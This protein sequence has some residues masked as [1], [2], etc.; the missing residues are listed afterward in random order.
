MTTR[1]I[2]FFFFNLKK[3]NSIFKILMT[4]K[5]RIEY[6]ALKPTACEIEKTPI[7]KKVIKW[8]STMENMDMYAFLIWLVQMSP[9]RQHNLLLW[10]AAWS[11]MQSMQQ[12]VHVRL[13]W[14]YKSQQ[15]DTNAVRGQLA[16]RTC[17]IKYRSFTGSS[18]QRKKQ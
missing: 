9:E 12:Y 17:G 11:Y 14:Y 5:G 13:I 15:Y 16:C 8:L 3:K 7:Q 1:E 2:S 18:G 4:K 6:A 10:S